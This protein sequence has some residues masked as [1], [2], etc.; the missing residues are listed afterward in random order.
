MLML[1][2]LVEMAPLLF[3]LKLLSSVLEVQDRSSSGSKEDGEAQQHLF[4]SHDSWAWWYHALFSLGFTI[5]EDKALNFICFTN[6]GSYSLGHAADISEVSGK[7][8]AEQQ[9]SKKGRG[10]RQW[11]RP[12]P[13][14]FQKI[15]NWNGGLT[16]HWLLLPPAM[17]L[18]RK[19][20]QYRTENKLN[21][22]CHEFMIEKRM[23][24]Q[25]LPLF[26][27]RYSAWSLSCVLLVGRHFA[28]DADI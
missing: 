26:S 23:S 15:H 27:A 3:W 10:R 4:C 13:C 20:F 8:Q 6:L 21:A 11:C 9:Q 18:W 2:S 24:P 22:H 17:V 16:F 28:G 14:F 5:T 7:E 25:P 1:W 19:F 12:D